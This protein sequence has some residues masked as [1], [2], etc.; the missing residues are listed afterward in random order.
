MPR[1]RVDKMFRALY[2]KRKQFRP[3]VLTP[4]N[5]TIELD[6]KLEPVM[7]ALS[8]ALQYQKLVL[9]ELRTQIRDIFGPAIAQWAGPGGYEKDRV[10][11]EGL[12]EQ[13]VLP[14]EQLGMVVDLKLSVQNQLDLVTDLMA[15]INAGE[16]DSVVFAR[17]IAGSSQK[18]REIV[19][20][21]RAVETVSPEEKARRAAF[22]EAW[23]VLLDYLPRAMDVAVPTAEEYA[24]LSYLMDEM[25]PVLMK[26][27]QAM[28]EARAKLRRAL[29]Q[30]GHEIPE[31]GTLGPLETGEE[32][33]EKAS[34]IVRA[35]AP[36]TVA[37]DTELLGNVSAYLG[38]LS[39]FVT[40]TDNFLRIV[41]RIDETNA[42]FNGL[43]Q[44]FLQ[45][46][47]QFVQTTTKQVQGG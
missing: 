3:A 38:A 37:L 26:E 23:Q 6:E 5:V 42:T 16:V 40:A 14:S 18:V 36:A 19:M 2:E 7:V 39:G 12:E 13:K 32:L 9:D 22:N 11:L 24:K 44:E 46:L 4:K 25:V 8:L 41:I 29:G 17:Q 34:A 33:G 45:A 30:L 47:D 1:E 35:Q 27:N 15:R 43:M 28:I 10:L 31:G 20:E 21:W